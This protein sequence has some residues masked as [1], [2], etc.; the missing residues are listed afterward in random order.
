MISDRIKLPMRFD[1][2]PLVRDL[3]NLGGVEW[4]EHFVKQNY[5]GNWSAL[6]LRA[7]ANATHP[8]MMIYSAPDAVA[9]C[10]TPL[11]QQLPH[12]RETLAWF[13]CP[14]Q[15]VRLM[16][17]TPG[18]VIKEHRD[19]DLDVEL[20][21]AR[22]HIP[23]TTNDSV[24]FRLNGRRVMMNQAAF[25]IFDFRKYTASVMQARPTECTSLSM[26]R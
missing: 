16:R 4:I 24:V 5:D 3:Q 14:L 11:L 10:D 13:E 26:P 8:I 22:L 19:L 2:V 20:G 15:C 18:S 6:P 25:G 21:T 7:Q 12:F 1:P 9:Y 23:V 17:L